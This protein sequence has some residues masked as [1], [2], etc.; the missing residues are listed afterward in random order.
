MTYQINGELKTVKK[1]VLDI[2]EKVPATRSDDK[3][4]IS[5]YIRNYGEPNS[6]ASID[7]SRRFWQNTMGKFKAKK[8]VEMQRTLNEECY[9]EVFCNR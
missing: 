2:L 6:Y 7:R 3:L 8:R 4:L 1:R 9:K 5:V